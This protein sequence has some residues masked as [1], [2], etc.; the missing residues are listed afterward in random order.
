MYLAQ[1]I[2]SSS[3]FHSSVFLVGKQKIFTSLL[4]MVGLNFFPHPLVSLLFPHT[5]ILS[6]Q[7]FCSIFHPAHGYLMSFSSLQ[8]CEFHVTESLLIYPIFKFYCHLSCHS[9]HSFHLFYVLFQLC[10]HHCCYNFSRHLLI[11]VRKC[12]PSVP[13]QIQYV[14]LSC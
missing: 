12:R 7:M 4:N 14:V 1:T 13:R 2:S 9:L 5:Q 6:I 3:L 11:Q 10:L 8:G